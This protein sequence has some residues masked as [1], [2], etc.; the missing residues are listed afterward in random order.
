MRL[1]PTEYWFSAWFFGVVSSKWHFCFFEWQI[2]WKSF[3]Y[4]RDFPNDLGSLETSVI[5]II[6]IVEWQEDFHVMKWFFVEK[7]TVESG[8]WID[9]RVT[10]GCHTLH[11]YM[12]CDNNSNGNYLLITIDIIPCRFV[13]LFDA[14]TFSNFCRNGVV[15]WCPSFS[16]CSPLF[17]PSSCSFVSHV[18]IALVSHNI[19]NS[20]ISAEY[21]IANI[22]SHPL[23]LAQ[24]LFA[25]RWSKA[26]EHLKKHN[27]PQSCST[28]IVS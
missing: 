7:L 13:Q 11:R 16:R 14:K 20:T 17:P 12:N 2:I 3:A 1:T 23:R 27:R 19:T 6:S 21:K 28:T 8:M 26:G 18:V 4:F 24:L 9:D 10:H 15:P 22:Y 5:I 25:K